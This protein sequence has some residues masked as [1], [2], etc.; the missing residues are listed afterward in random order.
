MTGQLHDSTARSDMDDHLEP[1]ATY[2]DLPAVYVNC[3]HKPSPELSY[4]RA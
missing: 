2:D 3:T 1:P 4:T